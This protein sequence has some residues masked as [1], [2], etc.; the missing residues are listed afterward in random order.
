MRLAEE[1]DAAGDRGEVAGHGGAR[2]FKVGGDDLEAK[3]TLSDLGLRKQDVA[4]FRAIRDAERAEPGVVQRTIDRIVERGE[5][6]TRAA[7]KRE[8]GAARSGG[9]SR[10][11]YGFG[12]RAHT[13][14]RICRPLGR[15]ENIGERGDDGFCHC[16]R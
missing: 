14:H 4:E 3:P 1:Y 7:L 8:I 6:P 12:S 15:L 5:E 9:L 11:R 16:V 10:A 2:N 13:A